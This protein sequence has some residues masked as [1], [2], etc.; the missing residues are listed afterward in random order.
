[1]KIDLDQATEHLRRD[2]VVIFPGLYA[3]Q[4]APLMQEHKRCF[5]APLKGAEL[6][7]P[8]EGEQILP[9][10][11]VD[12]PE[13]GLHTLHQCL[14]ANWFHE[15]GSRYFRSPIASNQFASICYDTP[16]RHLD[17]PGNH[18]THWDPT[19]SLRL[20]ILISDASVENGAIEVKRGTHYRNHATRLQLWE[21]HIEYQDPCPCA[22]EE[23]PFTPIEGRA[24]TAIVF[25][26][27]LTHRK[28]IVGPGQDR[29][30]AFSHV[31]S[32]LAQC[33]QAGQSLADVPASLHWPH[34]TPL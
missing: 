15:L 23:L 26:V 34:G 31:H 19:L 32:P 5:S 9:A 13:N 6:A 25:D 10:R 24:G 8:M 27:S 30:V 1:M 21:N 2:G 22:G 16:K 29:R 11:A 14:F 18:H 20:M 12:L 28:G 33:Q 3:D 17:G 7:P 4:C